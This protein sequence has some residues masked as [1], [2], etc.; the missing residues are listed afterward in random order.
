[1]PNSEPIRAVVLNKTVDIEPKLAMINLL[2][3]QRR[4]DYEDFTI[5][6]MIWHALL[7]YQPQN[8]ISISCVQR[9][10]VILK[11]LSTMLPF[12][13]ASHPHRADLLYKA[14]KLC[15][16][17]E[18]LQYILRTTK[19]CIDLNLNICSTIHEAMH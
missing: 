12:Y 11:L 19:A 15:Y 17:Q 18:V 13:K 4:E 1:M 6:N 3:E 16:E 10:V 9:Q 5:G 8:D 2:Q 7:F 14:V